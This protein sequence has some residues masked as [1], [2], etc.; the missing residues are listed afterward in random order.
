MAATIPGLECPKMLGYGFCQASL[1]VRGGASSSL[2]TVIQVRH[3]H[4]LWDHPG[5]RP[6]P[7]SYRFQATAALPALLPGLHG[8]QEV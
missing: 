8:V 4:H 6:P 2:S 7:R 5:M 1:F 3:G